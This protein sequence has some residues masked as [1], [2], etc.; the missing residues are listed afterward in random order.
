MENIEFKKEIESPITEEGK[1]I[2]KTEKRKVSYRGFLIEYDHYFYED[3]STGERFTTTEID[4]FH[5]RSWIDT[6]NKKYPRIP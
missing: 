4:E 2:L 3:Q 6:F 1:A 5:M